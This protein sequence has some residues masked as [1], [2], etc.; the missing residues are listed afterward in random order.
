MSKKPNILLYRHCDG[1]PGSIEKNN[2]GVLTDV[3]PFLQK[4]KEER[5]IEDFEYLSAWLIHHLIELYIK[6]SFVELNKREFT[7]YGICKPSFFL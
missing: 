5:G 1:C 7:G 4:F 2:F 6:N 3:V